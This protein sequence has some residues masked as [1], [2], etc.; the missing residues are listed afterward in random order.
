M[1]VIAYM[2]RKQEAAPWEAVYQEEENEG[3]TQNMRKHKCYVTAVTFFCLLFN[4]CVFERPN[5]LNIAKREHTIIH[6]K[7][8]KWVSNYGSKIGAFELYNSGGTTIQHRGTSTT[9]LE[10]QRRQPIPKNIDAVNSASD[11]QQ[12]NTV[13]GYFLLST[14]ILND[15][16]CRNEA[17]RKVSRKRIAKQHRELNSSLRV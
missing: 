11:G 4:A 10:L 3:H 5:L 14:A 8:R 7:L 16:L 2:Q 17:E 6:A 12:Q 13:S 1:G 9:P 15:G